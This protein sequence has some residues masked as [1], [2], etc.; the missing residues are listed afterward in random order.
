MEAETNEPLNY[1][2]SN[3]LNPFFIVSGQGFSLD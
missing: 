2:K 3:L 1:N